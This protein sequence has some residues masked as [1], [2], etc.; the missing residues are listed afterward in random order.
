MLQSRSVSN[1]RVRAT[2]KLKLATQELSDSESDSDTRHRP[3]LRQRRVLHQ[4]GLASVAPLA[5]STATATIAI[6]VAAI[7]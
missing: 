1:G 3:W 2:V 7:L 6:V 5:H 4:P